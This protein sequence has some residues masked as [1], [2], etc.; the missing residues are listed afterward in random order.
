MAPV[1]ITNANAPSQS[2]LLN[3][4][5][6]EISL[7]VKVPNPLRA[8]EIPSINTAAMAGRKNLANRDCGGSFGEI[9]VRRVYLFAY[10]FANG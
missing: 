1:P 8:S 2:T 6:S 4:T 3:I 9:I 10:C 5:S 7:T